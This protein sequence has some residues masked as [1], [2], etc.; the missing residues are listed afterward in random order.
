MS[1]VEERIREVVDGIFQD[2]YENTGLRYSDRMVDKEV[3]KILD[4]LTLPPNIYTVPIKPRVGKYVK[5]DSNGEI[6]NPFEEHSALLPRPEREP[7]V[8]VPMSLNGENVEVEV[9]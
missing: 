8:S 7:I 2:V 1:K 9:L 3:L 5:Y 6:I 4:I